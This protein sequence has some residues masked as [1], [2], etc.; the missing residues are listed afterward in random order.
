MDSVSIREAATDAIRWW[1]L[2]RIVYNATLGLIVVAYFVKS[3]P[4]S[5]RF[6]TLD[7][8][9]WLALLAILANVAYCAAYVPDIF[10][11]AS[12]YRE[13]WRRVRWFLF[14]VGLVL[15]AILTRWFSIAMFSAY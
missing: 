12:G 4:S 6:L 15:A 3:L 2:R 9:L 14:V 13:Q 5:R 7:G 10:A 8:V 1:E 11:Q